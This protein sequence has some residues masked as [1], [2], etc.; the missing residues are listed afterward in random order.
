MAEGQEA[1]GSNANG[2][3]NGASPYFVESIYPKPVIVD[4]SLP[5]DARRYLKQAIDTVFA[6]DASIVMSAAAIDA[7]LKEKGYEEGS[8][9]SRIDQAV[10][11]HVLT[12]SMGTWAHK[13]RLDANAVRHADGTRPPVD[14]ADARKVLEFSSALGDF[15]FVFSARVSEGIK[16]AGH[17]VALAGAT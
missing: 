13:V 14:E 5:E 7:M 6:P 10:K 4:A 16:D 17:S 11:D 3:R 9:Y 15:L 12:E 2:Y 1:I 8:L